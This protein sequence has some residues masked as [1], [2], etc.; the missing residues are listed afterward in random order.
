M[1]KQTIGI[2]SVANDGTGDP[3]RTA[4]DKVNDNFTELYTE[5]VN[6]ATVTTVP[7]TASY[8]LALTDNLKLVTISTVG[9]STVTV[10]PNVDVAFPVGALILVAATGAGQVSFAA[11]AG[12]TI[13]SADSALSLIGQYSTATLIKTA[14]NTWLLAGAIEL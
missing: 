13:N 7:Q 5:D 6:L 4:M 3:L 10:P 11:G 14:T 9:A 2:G 8:I 1:A 12:V